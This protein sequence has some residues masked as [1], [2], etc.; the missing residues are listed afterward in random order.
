MKNNQ[1]LKPHAG[2]G[3]GGDAL[4]DEGMILTRP[5]A[6]IAVVVALAIVTIIAFHASGSVDSTTEKG[7]IM[8]LPDRVGAFDG[9][10]QEPSEGEKN[11]LPKDTEIVKKT[12]SDPSGDVINA[13]IVLSGAEKRSIHRPEVCL[14]AQGWSINRRETFPVTL[15]DGRTITVMADYIS[16]PVEISPGVSRTLESIYCYWFVGN[17]VTTPSH[18]MRL[19]LTSWDRIVH[20]KNHRWAYVAVSAPVLQGFKQGGLDTPET[21]KKIQGFIAEAAPKLMKR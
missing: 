9:R 21:R 15:A 2:D 17:H 5:I 8:A 6:R 12:Y 19:L 16:R 20:R 1:G 18:V 4:Q 10:E 7:V 3:L 14:P 13:Q 11:V